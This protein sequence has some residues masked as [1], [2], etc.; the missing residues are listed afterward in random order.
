MVSTSRK[1]TLLLPGDSDCAEST[2]R[3]DHAGE[4]AAVRICE[5]QI[6]GYRGNDPAIL[7]SLDHTLEHELEHLQY[8]EQKIAVLGMEPT[9]ALPLW[10]ALSYSLGYISG[11]LGVTGIMTCTFAVERE[12][13][14]HYTEQLEELSPGELRDNVQRFYDDEVEHRDNAAEHLVSSSFLHRISA[15]AIS[16]GCRVAIE[17][18]KRW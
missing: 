10:D 9:M 18:S 6:A 12:I 3:V 11:R 5:G 16:L 8:F 7:A 2:I 17:I 14:L 13:A 4:H 1:I 15:R